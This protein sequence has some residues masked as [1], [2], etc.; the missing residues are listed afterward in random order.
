[1]AIRLQ[2]PFTAVTRLTPVPNL[3]QV[4]DSTAASHNL[5]YAEMWV[6]VF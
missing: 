4:P 6:V 3:S 1:M 5:A 2:G